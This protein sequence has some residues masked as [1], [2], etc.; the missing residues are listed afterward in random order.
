MGQMA[1]SS[2]ED[3]RGEISKGEVSAFDLSSK[4]S[5]DRVILVERGPSLL[6]VVIILV[7]VADSNKTKKTALIQCW[8]SCR[9]SRRRLSLLCR[10][11][12]SLPSYR[13]RNK[14]GWQ[15]ARVVCPRQL[16]LSFLRPLLVQSKTIEEVWQASRAAAMCILAR[17]QIALARF[18]HASR[19]FSCGMI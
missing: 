2:P 4:S 12:I 10:L 6:I 13:S 5:M 11:K 18:D 7:F 14:I 9:H 17:W 8:L 16:H 3:G 1:R 19:R 15:E